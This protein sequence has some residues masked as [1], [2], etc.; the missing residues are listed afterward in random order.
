MKAIRQHP[1][2]AAVVIALITAAGSG[3]KA[4]FDAGQQDQSET[5]IAVEVA[6]SRQWREM[7]VTD[8]ETQSRDIAEIRGQIADLREAVAEIR[9]AVELLSIGRRREAR[10]A[11]E[12]AKPEIEAARPKAARPYRP[13]IR[14]AK[15]KLE[16]QHIQKI[17]RQLFD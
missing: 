6:T 5:V 2:W 15:M 12:G 16:P 10:E 1:A 14:K 3:V 8:L 11:A 17:Q 4:Y 7:A 13:Q 9:V